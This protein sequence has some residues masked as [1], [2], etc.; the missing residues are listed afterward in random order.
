[1]LFINISHCIT[2]III[3]MIYSQLWVSRTSDKSDYLISQ[4]HL[5]ALFGYVSSVMLN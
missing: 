4:T 3:E 1:M 2:L 5:V